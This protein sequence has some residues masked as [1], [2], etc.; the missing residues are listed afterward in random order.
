MKKE[1]VFCLICNF[2]TNLTIDTFSRWHLK[3]QHNITMK[4]YYDLYLKK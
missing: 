1:K 3:S 2:Q 4:E